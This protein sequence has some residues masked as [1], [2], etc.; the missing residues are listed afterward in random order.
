MKDYLVS[1]KAEVGRDCHLGYHVVVEDGA[2]LGDGVVLGH[3]TVVLGDAWLEDR[4][5][6]GPYSILGVPPRSSPISARPC[7]PGGR[8]YIGPASRVGASA[9][10]SAGSVFGPCCYI[11]D[12]AAVRE[13]CVFGESTVVG[14]SVSVENDSVVGSRVMLQTG[15]YL[16][17]DC[18]IED[19]AFIGPAVVT[20]NDRYMSMW[21]EK[22]YRGPLVKRFAAIGAG[23][24]LLAGITVGEYAVVGMGAVVTGDVPPGRLFVGT[25]ARD[26]GEARVDGGSGDR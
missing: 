19:D 20:A 12:L 5:E 8:L 11:G 21:K 2:H 17:G 1:P 9:V 16:T 13:G 25:P 4:V 26:V 3:G 22:V 6:V 15:A 18:H 14:R 23:A 10:L 24:C 7:G